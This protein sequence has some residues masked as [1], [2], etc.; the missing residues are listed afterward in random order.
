M[1]VIEKKNEIAGLSRPTVGKPGYPK[2]LLCK[3][4]KHHP[5]QLPMAIIEMFKTTPASFSRRTPFTQ[6]EDLR[7]RMNRVA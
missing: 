3:S 6:L 2:D 7:I 4:I 1:N 5:W